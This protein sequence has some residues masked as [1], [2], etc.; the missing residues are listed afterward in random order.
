MPTTEM[1]IPYSCDVP[2][3]NKQQASFSTVC[4]NLSDY[5]PYKVY[6]VME[7]IFSNCR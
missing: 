2:A 3:N 1:D 5:L 7:G 4:K 6:E